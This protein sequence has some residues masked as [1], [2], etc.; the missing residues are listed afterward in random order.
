MYKY[1]IKLNK[2]LCNGRWANRNENVKVFTY[3]RKCI[4]ATLKGFK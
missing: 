4:R 3:V 2:E 1:K